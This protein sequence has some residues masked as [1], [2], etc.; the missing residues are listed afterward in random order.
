MIVIRRTEAQ[1]V[2]GCV[3]LMRMCMASRGE[4]NLGEMV[5]V[6]DIVVW[7]SLISMTNKGGCD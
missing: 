5:N 1:I 3:F 6:I 2:A 7:T 4:V